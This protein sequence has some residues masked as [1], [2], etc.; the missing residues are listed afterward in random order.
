M[1]AAEDVAIVRRGYEAFNT[2]DM[3]TLT[4]L[5]EESA[6]WHTPDVSS[7]RPPTGCRGPSRPYSEECR[8]SRSPGD[9]PRSSPWCS[10]FGSGSP[11]S[12]RSPGAEIIPIVRR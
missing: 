8:G 2:G 4:D 11:T 5:F 7:S 6:S 10:S 12:R 9:W 3:D 1:G